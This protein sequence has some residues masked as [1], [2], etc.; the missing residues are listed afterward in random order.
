[1]SPVGSVGFQRPVTEQLQ[2]S[3]AALWLWL[4]ELAR[5]PQRVRPRAHAELKVVG[6]AVLALDAL[7]G[8]VTGLV[9]FNGAVGPVVQVGGQRVPLLRLHVITTFKYKRPEERKCVRTDRRS[10]RQPSPHMLDLH[11]AFRT[12]ISDCQLSIM[13]VHPHLVVLKSRIKTKLIRKTEIN[14]TCTL[15]F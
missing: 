7:T 11:D 13:T 12:V 14:L 2:L 5:A 6:A 10:E 8:E 1:M 9:G 3:A 15:S 4:S